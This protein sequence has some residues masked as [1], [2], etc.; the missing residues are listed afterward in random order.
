MK[1]LRFAGLFLL[2]VLLLSPI[3]KLKLSKEKKP[4]L[5][6]Y[7]DRSASMDSVKSAQ[8]VSYLKSQENALEAQYDI[9]YF[10]FAAERSEEH[11][12]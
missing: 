1:A 8:L 5:L 4:A 7:V 10:D 9:R 11:N 3:L 6:V 12:V 2:F